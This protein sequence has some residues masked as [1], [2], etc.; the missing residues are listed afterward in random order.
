V[1]QAL[2]LEVKLEAG[3]ALFGTVQMPTLMPAT[4]RSMGTPASIRASEPPHTVAMDVDPLDSMIS[5]V[6]RTA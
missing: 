3:D 4:G 5:L 1:R 2:E 6:T